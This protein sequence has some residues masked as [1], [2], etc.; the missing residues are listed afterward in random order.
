MKINT[1]LTMNQYISLTRKIFE[2]YF[3]NDGEYSPALGELLTLHKFYETCVSEYEIK[4]DEN[5]A[6]AVLD[7][8]M[9]TPEIMNAYQ[10]VQYDCELFTFGDAVHKAYDMVQTKLDHPVSK[11]DE[12]LD[13]L[14]N[15]VEILKTKFRGMDVDAL[16]EQLKGIDF[17]NFNAQ[18]IVNAYDK[19]ERFNKNTNQVIEAKNKLIQKLQNENQTLRDKVTA[20]ESQKENVK[21]VLS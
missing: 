18:A 15:M 8:L 4:A 2:G 20:K 19:S 21:N 16:T 14:I 3:D 7:E 6:G 13:S 12:L 10:N 11:I 1:K 9:N 17:K 5:D